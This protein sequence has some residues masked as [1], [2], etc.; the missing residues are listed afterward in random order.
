MAVAT[1]WTVECPVIKAS[2][3]ICGNY[4]KRTC[5]EWLFLSVSTDM[6]LRPSPVLG[7]G[8]ESDGWPIER[9]WRVLDYRNTFSDYDILKSPKAVAAH[10][11]SVPSVG[12]MYS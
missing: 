6:G 4:H 5:T 12:R 8:V 10:Q 11:I 2:S 1:Y 3:D 7:E 9:L